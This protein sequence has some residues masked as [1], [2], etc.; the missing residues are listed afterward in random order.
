MKRLYEDLWQSTAYDAGAYRSH[1]WLLATA[2]GNALIYGLA[3]EGDLDG[4]AALG[5]AS[6]QLLSHRDEAGPMLNVV[7]EQLG[8]KLCASAPEASAIAAEAALDIEWSPDDRVVRGL[9]GLE[10]IHTPGHTDGSVCFFYRS[11]HGKSYLF[12]GDTIFQVDGRWRT[13]V[14]EEAGGSREALAASLRRLRDCAPDVVLFS[15]FVGGPGFAE[16]A[17]GEW[18]RVVDEAVAWLARPREAAPR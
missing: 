5:G 7:R 17:E 6:H 8:S 11:P 9:P 10:I 13:F 2:R 1:A 4:V 15:A 14:L 12:P 16:P 18:A 3:H